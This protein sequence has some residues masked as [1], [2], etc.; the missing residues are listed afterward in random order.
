MPLEAMRYPITPSGLHY[1]VIY[2]DIPD[3]DADT[4]RLNVGGLV[5]KPLR[6]SLDDIKKRPARTMAVTMG[7]A[8]NGRSLLSPRVISQPWFTEGIG[9]A[10][11]TGT[12]LKG[13]LDEAGISDDAVDIVFSSADPGNQG[14]VLQVY[15]RSLNLE[16]ANR[17]EMLLVYEMNGQPLQP[18]HGYPL[19]LLL[20]GWYGM[21]SVKWLDTIEA[22]STQ[23]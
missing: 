22:V 17:E 6:L 3:V 23:F 5:S 11:W 9:T 12:P 10:E 15:Q 8:R 1:M 19:R 4:W 18:Q 21:A 7:C 2:F 14:D 20:P 13:I 16:E